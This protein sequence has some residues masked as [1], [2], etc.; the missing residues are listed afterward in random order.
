MT[1]SM[2]MRFFYIHYTVCVVFTECELNIGAIDIGLNYFVT[3]SFYCF[4]KFI[5]LLLLSIYLS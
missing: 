2:Q 5:I 4:N 1:V 3:F